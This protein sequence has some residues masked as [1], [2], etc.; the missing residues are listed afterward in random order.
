MPSMRHRVLFVLLFNFSHMIWSITAP[1]PKPNPTRST[2]LP[3]GAR[4]LAVQS[5][6]KPLMGIGITADGLNDPRY[7]GV[8][9]KYFSVITPGNELKWGTLEPN[10][11][12]YNIAGARSQYPG[13]VD[14]ITKVGD[15]RQRMSMILE[16]VIKNYGRNAIAMD[17][18]NEILD[19]NGNPDNLPWKRIMGNKWYEEAFRMAKQFRDQYAP[20]MLLFL[21]D[22]GAEYMNP[23]ADGLLAIATS[24]YKQKLL[25]AVGFQCHF[26]ASHIPRHVFQKNLERFTAVGL[27]VAITEIDMRIQMNEQPKAV[28]KDLAAKTGDYEVIY[29]ICRRVK[30]CVS[31]T[32]WGVT[33]S[34]SWIGHV[35]YPG[36]GN[37]TLFENDFSPTPAMKQ[38]IKDGFFS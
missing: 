4:K 28:Q 31:V 1:E 6:N 22:F 38:L 35:E 15:M 16:F 37:A 26:A 36:F 8:V 29:G 13:W 2:K 24:L 20:Q 3:T 21:N 5:V 32:A 34:D 33:P 27:K 7:Q 23:K 11:G 10:P 12:A 19:K 14:G 17:V 30:G 25:D 18:C 9:T